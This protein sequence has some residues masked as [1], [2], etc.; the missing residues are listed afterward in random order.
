MSLAFLTHN[1]HH[2]L[3]TLTDQALAIGDTRSFLEL[4]VERIMQFA[5]RKSKFRATSDP[6]KVLCNEL[7]LWRTHKLLKKCHSRVLDLNELL[8]PYGQKV[9]VL[10][11]NPDDELTST[12]GSFLL[13]PGQPFNEEAHGLDIHS[14][15]SLV[16]TEIVGANPEAC[17]G[18]EEDMLDEASVRVFVHMRA[19]FRDHEVLTGRMY[20]LE[21]ARDSSHV[22]VEYEYNAA[23]DK[24]IHVAT[25]QYFVRI[26]TIDS[27]VV[28]LRFAM[29][30][31]YD[32]IA[33]LNDRD[34]GLIHKVDVTRFEQG[35]H[36]RWLPVL[37][38]SVQ[39]KLIH[40]TVGNQRYLVGYNISTGMY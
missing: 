1:L 31:F 40:C 23:G 16:R 26:E 15:F 3:C 20:G 8:P 33:P 9:G 27:H 36:G 35:N 2:L 6:E 22:S 11:A 7:E 18:W 24:K 21:R 30:H 4:W 10:Y 19:M 5:K 38:P 29:A 13:G 25:I 39:G 12:E 28:P 34:L 32:Y 14:L 17:Q 37:F